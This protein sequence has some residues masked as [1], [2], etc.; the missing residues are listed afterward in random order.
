MHE[1]LWFWEL[2]NDV[3]ARLAGDITEDPEFPKRQVPIYE[4]C[5]QCY[6]SRVD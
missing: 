2:H 5:P 1:V 3:N 4:D 6:W